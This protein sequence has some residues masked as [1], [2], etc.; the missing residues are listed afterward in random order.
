M[1]GNFPKLQAEI[2]E[3]RMLVHILRDLTENILE[4]SHAPKKGSHERDFDISD[5]EEYAKLATDVINKTFQKRRKLIDSLVRN[6]HAR[7]V[8]GLTVAVP[9]IVAGRWILIRIRRLQK[10]PYRDPYAGS[11]CADSLRDWRKKNGFGLDKAA[12]VL[13]MSLNEYR[14]FE[15]GYRMP[16]MEQWEPVKEHL[17]GEVDYSKFA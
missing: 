1:L 13:N 12:K 3:M 8:V 15:Y 7:S 14:D 9:F 16:N 5:L 4:D 10:K 6:E 11:Y 2:F 17:R